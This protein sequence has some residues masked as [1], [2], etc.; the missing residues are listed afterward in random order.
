[1]HLGNPY[2]FPELTESRTLITAL[3]I[4]LLVAVVWS[5]RDARTRPEAA[6]GTALVLLTVAT[7]LVLRAA[8]RLES[9]PHDLRQGRRSLEA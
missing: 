7:A 6:L 1:V 4:G 8:A 3:G 2:P 9:R 5:W